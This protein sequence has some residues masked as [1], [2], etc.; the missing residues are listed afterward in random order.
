MARRGTDTARAAA[1][2]HKTADLRHGAARHH[3]AAPRAPQSYTTTP[4]YSTT[5]LDESC[6]ASSVYLRNLECEVSSTLELL[7]DGGE[8]GAAALPLA[9]ALEVAGSGTMPSLTKCILDRW[10]RYAPFDMN[11]VSQKAH[12]M[13]ESVITASLQAQ[14]KAR[15]A[16]GAP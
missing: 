13:I 6:F 9:L 4:G 11:G 10:W 3:A 2:Q 16:P 14:E 15:M 5:Y 8:R 12:F 7:E 1:N